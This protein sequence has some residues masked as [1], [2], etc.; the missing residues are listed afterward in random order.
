MS[1]QKHVHTINLEIPMDFWYSIEK[2]LVN[3]KIK[4][5]EKVNK[6]D[7]LLRLIEA[8]HAKIEKSLNKDNTDAS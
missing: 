5:G 3:H 6:K 4:T 8:G 2:Q 1:E 7:F